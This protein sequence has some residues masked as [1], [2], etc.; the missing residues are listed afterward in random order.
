MANDS[1]Y[2][3][4]IDTKNAT[5]I[6]ED[7]N[8]RRSFPMASKEAFAIASKAW[9]RCGWDVKH[10]YTFSW[11]GRPMIQLPEDMIRVQELIW[12][13]RPDVIIETGVAHGGS[14]VF[15]ASLC[16]L[17]GHGRVIGIEKGLFPQNKKALSEHP[18]SSR[19]EIVEG[20]STDPKVVSQV[21]GMISS[22]ERVF[23]MFDS[24]HSRQ[25][26]L[27]ELE[28]YK[29][30]IPAGS[31]MIACDGIMKD[32]VG[33][34]RTAPDWA[35]N[36][37]TSAAREFVKRH[38]NFEIFHPSFTYNDGHIDEPVTYWPDGIVRRIS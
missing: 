35:D 6:V 29:D 10:I 17:M 9:L 16:Q 20:S 12:N 33:G 15:T 8:G 22:G 34:P 1:D 14:L 18:L 28:S 7:R 11:L 32:V 27:D 37:P 31:F 30:L 24:N 26:V 23:A 5:V 4:Q 21:H 3:V 25:H 13:L 19:F 38:E 2:L 36:N